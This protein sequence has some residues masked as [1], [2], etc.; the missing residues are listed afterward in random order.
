MQ[1]NHIQVGQ[2]YL[3]TVG[4]YEDTLSYPAT[5]LALVTAIDGDTVTLIDAL[6][7]GWELEDDLSSVLSGL[8]AIPIAE[9]IAMAVRGAA[10]TY[11]LERML[12]TSRRSA[13]E[14]PR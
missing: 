12:H 2:Y 7:G 5:Y 3:V 14:L 4:T 6:G 1:T 13:R 10:L 11:N 9:D 8:D